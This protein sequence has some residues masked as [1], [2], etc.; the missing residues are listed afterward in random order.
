MNGAHKNIFILTHLTQFELAAAA[1]AVVSWFAAARVPVLMRC[2][3]SGSAAGLLPFLHLPSVSCRLEPVSC[4]FFPPSPDAIPSSPA[5]LGPVS[6]RHLSHPLYV[7]RPS[8]HPPPPPPTHHQLQLPH[9]K[10]HNL[11]VPCRPLRLLHPRPLPHSLLVHIRRLPGLF[12]ACSL[13]VARPPFAS[14]STPVCFGRQGQRPKYIYWLSETWAAS[15]SLASSSFASALGKKA[16]ILAMK[17]QLFLV[18]K[19]FVSVAH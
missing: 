10:S 15:A 12:V 14:L 13:C 2:S 16:G 11:S 9:F 6:C 7:N 18:L 1:A 8:P 17:V 19:A 4:L 3:C 5:F